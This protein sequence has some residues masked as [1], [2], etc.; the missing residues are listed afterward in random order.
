MAIRIRRRK[1]NT[2]PGGQSSDREDL[3][4]EERFR[5]DY[6]GPSRRDHC[7]P[8]GGTCCSHSSVQ[9]PQSMIEVLEN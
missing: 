7:I 8:Q 3:Y 1:R 6:T 5:L 9:Q 4:Q 2:R